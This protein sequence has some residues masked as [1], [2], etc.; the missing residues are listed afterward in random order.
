MVFPFGVPLELGRVEVD[1]P[2][3]AGAVP[4]GLI[5]EVLRFRVAALAA[6]R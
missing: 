3:V 4:L 1:F 5:V 2:Q 6:R